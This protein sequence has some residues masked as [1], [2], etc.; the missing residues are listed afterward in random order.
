MLVYYGGFSYQDA[1]HIPIPE[2]VWF[3]QRT[4]QEI[5]KQNGGGE[6]DAKENPQPLIP[7]EVRALMNMAGPHNRKSMQKR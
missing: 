5:N 2:R 6:N 3:I 7:P 4:I 1:L